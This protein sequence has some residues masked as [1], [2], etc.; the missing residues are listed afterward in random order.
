MHHLNKNRTTIQTSEW[1]WNR[2]SICLT[3]PRGNDFHSTIIIQV[4]IT[5]KK[6]LNNLINIPHVIIIN[7]SPK[8]DGTLHHFCTS[9]GALWTG[10]NTVLMW[11]LL[12]QW[13]IW[14]KPYWLSRRVE[15]TQDQTFST[16]GCLY[17]G[18]L[19]RVYMLIP[20]DGYPDFSKVREHN[21]AYAHRVN[22]LS[23]CR[24]TLQ[25]VI[26]VSIL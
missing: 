7:Q 4:F 1:H 20:S 18:S 19:Y 25:W 8:G 24:D 14:G 2:I 22:S 13:F 3:N 21:Y 10:E 9:I 17:L 12:K 15:I 23:L 26:Q 5:W 6:K 16:I 11:K